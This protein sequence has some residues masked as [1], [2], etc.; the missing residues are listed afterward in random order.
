MPGASTASGAAAGSALG[1]LGT[2]GG[3][4]VGGLFD[5]LGQSSANKA[6]WK[7]AKAQMDFQERMSNTAWQ[8]AVK[9]MQAA[10][11]NP[12]LAVSQG[13]AS[14][15]AGAS[16]RMESVTGG[17]MGD[18]AVQ[19]LS[20]AAQVENV[21]AQTRLTNQQTRALKTDTDIKVYGIPEEYSGGSAAVSFDILKKNAA[22][23]GFEVESSRWEAAQKQF[24]VETLN[25]IIARREAALADA[26]EQKVPQL[27]AD[28]AF[29][30]SLQKEGGIWAKA[31]VFLKSLLR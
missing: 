19:A 3:A 15:P 14:S 2:I 22:K 30:Q 16:A 18:R 6:N 31:A 24:G 10:G 13:P 29:W 4:I 23:A 5:V 1:P 12:M 7:I 17:R 26:A 25:A 27:K 11:I 21:A 20:T 8:R 9:D 28:A